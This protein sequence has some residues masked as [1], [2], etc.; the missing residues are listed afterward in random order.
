MTPYKTRNTAVMQL[1]KVVLVLPNSFVISNEQHFESRRSFFC[2]VIANGRIFQDKNGQQVMKLKLFDAAEVSNRTRRQVPRLQLI[3]ALPQGWTPRVY[4]AT[5]HHT[6]MFQ[7][8]IVVH[9]QGN[10]SDLNG[11]NQLS[12]LEYENI[13]NTLVPEG[14]LCLL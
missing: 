8:V 3:V 12:N 4:L 14:V 1:R 6:I 5:L 2:R 10:L 9:N 13:L 11:I 7:H